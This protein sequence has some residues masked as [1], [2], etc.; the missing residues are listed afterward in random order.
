MTDVAAGVVLVAAA[1]VGVAACVAVVT[2]VA[3]AA[4][5]AAASAAGVA[6]G[7]SSL[8]FLREAAVALDFSRGRR[9]ARTGFSFTSLG[10]SSLASLASLASFDCL[11]SLLGFGESVVVLFSSSSFLRRDRLAPEAR[12]VVG[13][14]LIASRGVPSSLGPPVVGLSVDMVKWQI[15]TQRIRVENGDMWR[16]VWG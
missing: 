6:S 1:G 12:R 13:V 11:V 3:V 10:F 9:W 8:G 2:G 15:K 14:S 7:C 16:K 5:G 4:V